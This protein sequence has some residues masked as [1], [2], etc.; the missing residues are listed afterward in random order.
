MILT[1]WVADH[2][3]LLDMPTRPRAVYLT[4]A[5]HADAQ[6]A[7]DNSV[8]AATVAR[9]SY[10]QT[11]DTLVAAG[12]LEQLPGGRWQVLAPRQEA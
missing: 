9:L 2:P 7:P 1:P 12:L 8:D 5:V 3:T 6:G 4:L 10:K 11:R